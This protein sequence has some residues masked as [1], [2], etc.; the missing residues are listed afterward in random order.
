MTNFKNPAKLSKKS[1][2][3]QGH[4][5]PKSCNKLFISQ[6]NQ[7]I[8]YRSSWE[9]K[10]IIFCETSPSIKHWGSECIAVKYKSLL[11]GKLHTYY[12]DFV[13]ETVSGK[14][15]VIEIKPLKQTK[16][17]SNFYDHKEYLKNISK[18][19]ALRQVCKKNNYDFKILTESTIN[20]LNDL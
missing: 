15:I 7:I 20:H 17:S 3:S 4:I 18:W 2:Y 14:K 11:D 5:N 6:S 10:F 16:P 12:P 19:R 13:I 8:T 9:K 1:R